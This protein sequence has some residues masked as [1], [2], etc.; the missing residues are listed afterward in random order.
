MFQ[1]YPK[2][3]LV[4]ANDI[5][6]KNEILKC[7]TICIMS[8]IKITNLIKFEGLKTWMSISTFVSFIFS[9]K[10]KVCQ[11]DILQA[12]IRFF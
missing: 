9:S 1:K 5:S 4:K 8:Y 7:K 6:Y 3:I 11:V 10:Y 12:H 2:Q